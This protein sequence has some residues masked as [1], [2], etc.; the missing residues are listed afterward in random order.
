VAPLNWATYNKKTVKEIIKKEIG[1]Q[2]YGGKH[3]ESVFTKFYQNYILPTKFN[4]D[5]RKAHLSNLI[6]SNQIT[7]EEAL[8]ELKLPLY[9]SKELIQDKEYVIK[10]LGFTSTEFDTLMKAP[11]KNHYDF[12]TEGPIEKHYQIIKPFKAIYKLF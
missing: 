3:H 1:W 11:P 5:K 8:G 4:I 7:K 6:C 9:D 10:K 2:D 12:E